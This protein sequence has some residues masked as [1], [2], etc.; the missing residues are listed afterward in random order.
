MNFMELKTSP[1]MRCTFRDKKIR[2]PRKGRSTCINTNWRN[3]NKLKMFITAAYAVCIIKTVPAIVLIKAIK[4]VSP[5]AQIGS[6]R[7][8][9]PD[10]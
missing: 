5:N 7:V 9:K 8:L 10:T 3:N 1:S 4:I 6:E 2:M